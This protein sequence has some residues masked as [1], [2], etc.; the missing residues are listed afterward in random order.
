MRRAALMLTFAA[1][2]ACSRVE[3][4]PVDRF[5][6]LT[7][8]QVQAGAALTAGTLRVE[9]FDSDGLHDGRAILYSEDAAGRELKMHH[10]RFWA[11][12]PPR[13]LHRQMIEFLRAA[14]AAGRVS[15]EP[16]ADA[17]LVVHGRVLRFETNAAGSA[18]VALE[19]GLDV[20]DA[21]R[22]T[23]TYSAEVEA[24]RSDTAMAEAFDRAVAQIFEAFL[25]DAAGAVGGR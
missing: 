14:G 13:M 9:S 21:N 4:V 24:G 10:Y 3:P 17:D 1:V 23:R 5:Y 12:S 19:L 7:Q 2:A 15:G 8:P 25:A 22:F 18:Q 11:D 20:A 16:S 6:R